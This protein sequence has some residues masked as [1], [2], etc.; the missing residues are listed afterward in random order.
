MKAGIHLS[1][2]ETYLHSKLEYE[3]RTLP[4]EQQLF[5]LLSGRKGG[6]MYLSK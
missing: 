6:N 1:Y 5:S 4:L 2:G 3:L